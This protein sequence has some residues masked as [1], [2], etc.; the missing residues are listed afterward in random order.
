[1]SGP[2]WYPAYQE[3]L[4]RGE[5]ID[6]GKR[7]NKALKWGEGSWKDS[8]Q[9]GGKRKYQ[10]GNSP[11]EA[12]KIYTRLNSPI[13]PS[14]T[15]LLD[16]AYVY[17]DT[18]NKFFKPTED[19][20]RLRVREILGE[21]LKALAYYSYDSNRKRGR[22]TRAE[23]DAFGRSNAIDQALSLANP[24]Q[25]ANDAATSQAGSISG[26]PDIGKT[27]TS[28]KKALKNA[29]KN[30]LENITDQVFKKKYYPDVDFRSMS[31]AQRKE[32]FRNQEQL[33]AEDAVKS[34]AKWLE[35][36]ITHPA[37]KQRILNVTTPNEYVPSYE[38]I[39]PIKGITLNPT[40]NVH[41]T[42][43]EFL[44]NYPKLFE[45][46]KHA[47]TLGIVP[48]S[49]KTFDELPKKL[50]SAPIH[51]VSYRHSREARQISPW[52]NQ[53]VNTYVI[54]S[55]APTKRPNNRLSDNLQA[56]LTTKTRATNKNILTAIHE[57]THDWANDQVVEDIIK[58]TST[59]NPWGVVVDQSSNIFARHLSPET[60]N[61]LRNNKSR[62]IKYL[63]EPTEIH[64]R[65]MELRRM[66]NL[67]PDQIV[68]AD[69][70]AKMV[71]RNEKTKYVDPKFFE[72]FSGKGADRNKNI[73]ELFNV[74]PAAIVGGVGVGIMGANS[75]AKQ[76]NS[77]SGALSPSTG[78]KAGGFKY[79]RYPKKVS[80][81]NKV[82]KY[83]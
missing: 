59:P 24:F 1:M 58:N 28:V 57:G 44:L 78:L 52:N 43:Q 36:W 17:G 74:L 21:P 70:V 60:L 41:Q 50:Q 83:S 26:L 47:E 53:D 19:P 62:H 40:Y 64:A 69:D 12:D 7:K 63:S 39:K 67:R 6:F 34:G 11:E 5:V 66:M 56:L 55:R 77:S 32:F 35:D 30:L 4:K 73:A 76:E 46:T 75:N 79:P 16:P 22:P 72:L 15:N 13:D 29:P 37:T 71:S 8:M 38:L 54:D 25:I 18:Q 27:V 42:P 3:A 80:Y 48:I 61:I 20:E 49:R 23:W 51:G 81:N 10:S 9:S 2:E 33:E 65:I 45:G 68:T 82:Q 31:A 14:T